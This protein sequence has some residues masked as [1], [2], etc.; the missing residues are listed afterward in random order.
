[1][2]SNQII[3]RVF[4]TSSFLLDI[5]TYLNRSDELISSAIMSFIH[6]LMYRL[7]HIKSNY[8]RPQL[9]YPTC[10]EIFF[11]LD[12]FKIKRIIWNITK[13]SMLLI[14]DINK[15]CIIR[16]KYI[17]HSLILFLECSQDLDRTD[18]NHLQ[19]NKST[20]QRMIVLKYLT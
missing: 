20:R 1:M 17:L 19:I 8:I 12:K 15:V 4:E 10:I 3:W 11:S 9:F 14:D 5:Y 18:I 16:V 13:G 2:T 7:F 6:Y